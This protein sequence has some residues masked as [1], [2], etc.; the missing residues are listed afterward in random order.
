MVVGT[1]NKRPLSSV[2]EGGSFT[3]EM[4]LREGY[5]M[6]RFIASRCSLGSCD[7]TSG[8]W[9]GVSSLENGRLPKIE[10]A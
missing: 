3:C 4:K 10:P 1:G 2:P 6:A 7:S 5:R 9:C 8:L